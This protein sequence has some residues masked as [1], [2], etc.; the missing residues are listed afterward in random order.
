MRLV[1]IT[2]VLLVVT[3]AVTVALSEPEYALA[4]RAGLV[5]ELAAA[6]ALAVAGAVATDRRRGALLIVTAGAWTTGEWAN[7]GAGAL[8]FTIGLLVA[9]ATPALLAHA[10]SRLPAAYAGTALFVGAV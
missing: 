5:L 7:P 2:G 8:V 10:L 3:V 6:V 4:T 1:A 9:P